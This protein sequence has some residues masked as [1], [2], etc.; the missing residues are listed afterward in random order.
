[1]KEGVMKI[2]LAAVALL[3]GIATAEAAQIQVGPIVFQGPAA[4]GGTCPV[5]GPFT[6]PV[7]AGTVICQITVAPAN[8]QGVLSVD[9]SA[10]FA[11]SGSNLVTAVAIS[12]PGS[13]S[14]KITTLP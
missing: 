10:H 8:W 7:A 3:F 4:T 9:D 12:A 5:S 2:L 1:M 14:P 13:F 11:I 6:I